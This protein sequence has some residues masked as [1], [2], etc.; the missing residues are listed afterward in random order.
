MD[1]GQKGIRRLGLILGIVAI[2]AFVWLVLT[3]GLL[4]YNQ[5]RVVFQ[6]P[7]IV[8]H[9]PAPAVRVDFPAA[10]GHPLHGYLVLP[11]LEHPAPPAAVTNRSA[12]AVVVAFHGNAD[13]AAWLVPWA[14]ELSRRSGFPVFLPELRGYGGISGSSS[15]ASAAADSRGA[16]AYVRAA[17]PGARIVLF[18]HSLGSAL[19]AEAAEALQPDRPAALVLQSPFTS[20]RDMAVRMLVP[21]IPGLWSAISRVHYDTRAIVQ[22][23]DVPVWVAHGTRDVVI[24]IRMGR[25]VFAAARRQGEFL[26]VP[27]AGHND[28]ADVGEERYWRWLTAALSAAVVELEKEGDR[29]LPG[30]V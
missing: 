4:W 25:A 15:Y 13:L 10:D 18:G 19:A 5:E 24:P 28:V 20:A 11:G 16:L 23:L 29:R 8:V 9:P 6:P 2:A 21:P 26:E 1:N 22:R 12:G 14:R 17:F 3:I 30:L 7:G 27:G